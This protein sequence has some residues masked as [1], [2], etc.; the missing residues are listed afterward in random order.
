MLDSAHLAPSTWSSS[1]PVKTTLFMVADDELQRQWGQC[2]ADDL[3]T[4]VSAISTTGVV[5][6]MSILSSRKLAQL[7]VQSLLLLGE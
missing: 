2:T 3:V 7:L 1:T 5:M 4:F 6:L